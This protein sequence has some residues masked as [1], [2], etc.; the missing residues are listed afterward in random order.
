MKELIAISIK[1]LYMTFCNTLKKYLFLLTH[2]S[3]SKPYAMNPNSVK[4]DIKIIEYKKGL[5]K[6]KTSLPK[7]NGKNLEKP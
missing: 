3:N 4:G 7:K 1:K 6:L 5:M 2:L